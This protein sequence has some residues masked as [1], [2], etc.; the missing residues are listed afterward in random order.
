MGQST[1]TAIFSSTVISA[2][3]KVFYLR[4]TADGTPLL[5]RILM[6][7]EG[8]GRAFTHDVGAGQRR[9]HTRGLER[10]A[11]HSRFLQ[12]TVSALRPDHRPLGP[13]R[14]A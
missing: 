6:A 10:D 8:D 11:V 2:D 1:V 9:D 12:R 3:Y 14:P 5:T 4:I 13:I 7:R